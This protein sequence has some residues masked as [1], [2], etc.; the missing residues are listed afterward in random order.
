MSHLKSLQSQLS[1][2]SNRSDGILWETD[3]LQELFPLE[4]FQIVKQAKTPGVIVCTDISEIS[5]IKEYLSES[6]NLKVMIHLSDEYVGK[7]RNTLACSQLYNRFQ[8]VLRQHALPLNKTY[9]NVIQ[10]PLGYMTNMFIDNFKN[11]TVLN[12]YY[13]TQVILWSSSIHSD[14]RK[15]KWSFI[16][17]LKNDRPYALEIFQKWGPHFIANNLNSSAMRYVY[18]DSLFVLVGRGWH[19]TDCF[20]IY[21][22][23]ICGAIP[24]VVVNN[25]LE[26]ENTFSFP[27]YNAGGISVVYA[28]PPI[29]FTY[30]WT[31]ALRL[32][33]SMS[34]DEIDKRRNELLIWYTNRIEYIK[35]NIRNVFNT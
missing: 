5:M 25:K 2:K 13:S 21:E 28:Y 33:Q 12:R 6:K 19:S 23:I 11:S 34:F 26:F 4:H 35:T 7:N 18:N 14:H 1:H 10:I 16:G 17:H 8:L 27:V 15:F 29:L 30:N 24:I 31:D 9:T 32:C 20:R 22:A 3:Y